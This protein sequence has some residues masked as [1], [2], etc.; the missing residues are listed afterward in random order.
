MIS[1]D[2]PPGR[3]KSS[4]AVSFSDPLTPSPLWQF[5][6][7]DPLLLITLTL[8]IGCSS[9]SPRFRGNTNSSVSATS[10]QPR[11][12]TKVR[13]E[14]MAEDDKKVDIEV[15]KDRFT[16]RDQTPLPENSPR[17][18]GT[19]TFDRKK[20]MAEI[21]ALLGT[22]YSFGSSDSDGMD[23]SA[24]TSH[25]YRKAVG[26]PL[27]RSTT[28]QYKV[29]ESVGGGKLQFGDLLFFNTTGESPS[30]VGIFIGDDIF[31]H[32]SISWGVT[33]SSLQSSYYKK[34]FI[35]ARRVVE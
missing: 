30:H 20:V 17:W 31:A 26:R 7:W 5:H 32:A 29:G 16:D 13:Q 4:L 10:N 25:I 33:I 8:L 12:A 2:T 9:S 15:V 6:R 11:F 21:V 19:S 23:C 22:P 1:T 14:E 18:A 27:P 34:R 28:D 24:F 3:L 35:G